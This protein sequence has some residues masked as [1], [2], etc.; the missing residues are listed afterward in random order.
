METAQLALKHHSA[1]AGRKGNAMSSMTL[2]RFVAPSVASLAIVFL[3]G[4]GTAGAEVPLGALGTVP[5]PKPDLTGFVRDEAAA[6]A[7]GKALFWDMQ[8]GRGGVQARGACPLH[9]GGDTQT[10]HPL[11]L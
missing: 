11:N 2:K 8:L 9:G 1:G 3:L 6:V 5:V 4:A 10:Q 7:L